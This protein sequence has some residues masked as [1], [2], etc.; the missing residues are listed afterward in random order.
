MTAAPATKSTP[1]PATATA[2]GPASRTCPCI[3]WRID[4]RLETSGP[5]AGAACEAPI[6]TVAGPPTPAVPAPAAAA[7]VA[8]Q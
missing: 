3:K 1:A 2:T 4:R 7:P 5:F 8:A 6:G